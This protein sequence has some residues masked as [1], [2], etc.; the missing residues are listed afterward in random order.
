[1]PAEFPA[2]AYTWQL[3]DKEDRPANPGRLADEVQVVGGRKLKLTNYRSSAEEDGIRGRCVITISVPMPVDEDIHPD[4]PPAQEY[5]SPYF[6][7]KTAKEEV[8]GEPEIP[9]EEGKEE[10][11]EGEVSTLSPEEGA[12]D[13]TGEV[14]PGEKEGPVGKFC[15]FINRKLESTFLCPIFH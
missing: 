7:F 13:G 6:E 3:I 12:T 8:P 1:M 15:R 11:G 4:M 2:N 14:V 9:K 10:T 5:M